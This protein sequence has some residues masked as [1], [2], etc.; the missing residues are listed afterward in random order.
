MR[1][2]KKDLVI[3]IC[4]TDLRVEALDFSVDILLIVWYNFGRL[5]E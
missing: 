3:S 1:S 5:R 2:G 4:L